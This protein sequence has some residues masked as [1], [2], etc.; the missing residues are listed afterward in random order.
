MFFAAAA[1]CAAAFSVQIGK[2]QP[3][4]ALLLGCSVALVGIYLLCDAAVSLFSSLI[5]GA[6]NPYFTACCKALVIAL[7]TAPLAAQCKSSGQAAA[8]NAIE[9]AA[10]AAVL[11][12]GMPILQEVLNLAKALLS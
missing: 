7:I 5:G 3:E 6:E 10:C 4:L 11:Q 8:A 1:V 12:V 9:Y 2:N